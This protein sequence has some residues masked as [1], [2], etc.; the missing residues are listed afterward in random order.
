MTGGSSPNPHRSRANGYL[1]ICLAVILGIVLTQSRLFGLLAPDEPVPSNDP[2][3]FT[4]TCD[5]WRAK[6]DPR[7]LGPLEAAGEAPAPIPGT[8]RDCH[9]TARDS[10]GTASVRVDMALRSFP[11]DTTDDALNA[12]RLEAM[13]EPCGG[14]EITVVGGLYNG[15]ACAR[16]AEGLSVAW[17]GV[18]GQVTVVVGIEHP[19]TSAT[20]LAQAAADLGSAAFG[21]D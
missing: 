2:R 21:E 11:L 4:F 8:E 14:S 1:A 16:V 7:H 6:A 10:A 15:I 17:S 12:S 20:W 18:L 19:D 5:D 3:T 13:R 9:S